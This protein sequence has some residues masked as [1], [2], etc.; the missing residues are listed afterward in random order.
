MLDRG[1]SDILSGGLGD[2]GTRLDP[3]CV[4]IDVKLVNIEFA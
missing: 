4:G 1:F 2:G 3:F